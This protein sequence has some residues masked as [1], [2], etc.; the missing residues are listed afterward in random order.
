MLQIHNNNLTKLFESMQLL[1]NN[2]LGGSGSRGSG[3]IKFKDIKIT[4]RSIEFYTE[5]AEEEIIAENLDV[6]GAINTL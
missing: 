6:I 5:N 1:E 3:Q 4:K 2:Y